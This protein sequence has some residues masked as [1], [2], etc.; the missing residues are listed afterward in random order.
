MLRMLTPMLNEKN[1][2]TKW[3]QEFAYNM[4]KYH[5]KDFSIP[6]KS[7]INDEILGSIRNGIFNGFIPLFVEL[8]KNPENRI[9][10]RFYHLKF[11]EYLASQWIYSN[12][13]EKLNSIKS[14]GLSLK[15]LPKKNS[16][17]E[18]IFEEFIGPLLY[19]VWY[20]Q[21]LLFLISMFDEKIWNQLFDWIL[22]SDDGSGSNFTLLQKMID[23]RP[24]N[25][26]PNIK[27]KLK[28]HL[29]SISKIKPIADALLHPS[30]HLQNLC[31]QSPEFE[32]I[33]NNPTMN[34]KLF[35]IISSSLLDNLSLIFQVFGKEDPRI[36]LQLLDD[37][38]NGKFKDD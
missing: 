29:Q 37:L 33:K 1:L 32:A 15:F 21:T 8:G 13:T 25:E 38:K 10:F 2:V 36:V 22:N 35:N 28:K 5:K 30:I 14:S 11:Q 26:H 16:E 3:I 20:R 12:L 27:E 9:Q 19:D 18:N 4:M 24:E 23:Y 17:V 7:N 34:Q 31:L 6:S